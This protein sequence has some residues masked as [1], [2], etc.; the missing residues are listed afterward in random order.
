MT[1]NMEL[2]EL[3]REENRVVAVL[4]NTMTGEEEERLVDTVVVEC[5]SLPLEALY[6]DLKER[7]VNHGVTDLP[8]LLEGRTQPALEQ[9]GPQGFALFR[10]G[11]AVAGRNIHAAIYDALR[12]CKDF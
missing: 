9:A 7:S 8:A 6:F 11:D 10:I 12:L 2:Q 5:G 1:P 4:R 3:Y